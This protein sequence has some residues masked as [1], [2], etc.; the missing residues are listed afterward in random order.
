M[1]RSVGASSILFEGEPLV[2]PRLRFRP[3]ETVGLPAAVE[4]DRLAV[5]A[6]ERPVDAV[7]VEGALVGPELRLV[8]V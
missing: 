5:E 2:G 1:L 6:D 4:Q 7:G 8:D 3:V